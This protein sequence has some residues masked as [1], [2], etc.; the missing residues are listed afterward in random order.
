MVTFL[1]LPTVSLVVL[2]GTMPSAALYKPV[3]GLKPTT[4][5]KLAGILHD[6]AAWGT[7]SRQSLRTRGVDLDMHC[8]HSNG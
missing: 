7:V 2:I 4:P 3:V 1:V 5:V 8:H 6:P